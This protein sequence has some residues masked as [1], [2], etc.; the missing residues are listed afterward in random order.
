MKF[1][2]PAVAGPAGSPS[3]LARL[4]ATLVA[5]AA[6]LDSS[7]AQMSSS[8]TTQ[9]VSRRGDGTAA[10][11]HCGGTSLSGDGRYVCFG[12]RDAILPEDD[13][14]KMDVYVL[15]RETGDIVCASTSSVGD[16]GN[17]S[18]SYGKISAD[19]RFV[20]FGNTSDDLIV[21]DTNGFSDVF[22]KDLQTGVLT[23]ISNAIGSA[24][25]ANNHAA[26]PVLS[27]NGRYVAFRSLAND[28][29]VGDTNGEMD[30]FR[31]DRWT[32]TMLRVSNGPAGE[33][34]GDST[35]PSISGD[36]SRIAFVSDADNLT[37]G[38][39]N[40]ERDVFIVDVG[41]LPTLVTRNEFGLSANGSSI[42][43]AISASGRHVA[44]T[45]TAEDLVGPLNGTGQVVV[46]RLED[47]SFELVSVDPTGQPGSD[48]SGLATLS[49]DGRYVAFLS[50]TN[51]LA[52]YESVMPDIFVRDTLEDCTWTGSRPSGTVEIA[53]DESLW[54]AL[55][56]DGSLLAFTSGATN[57]VPGD[58]NAHH[59]VFLREMHPDPRAYCSATP[60]PG[61]CV[62]SIGTL[63]FPSSGSNFGFTVYAEDVPN[64]SLGFVFYGFGGA[65]EA[66]FQG[67]TLC[68]APVLL[69]GPILHSG[70]SPVGSDCTGTFG[71]DMNSY[72]AG[73]LGGSPHV[74]L[75]LI[76]Q[77]VRLQI[78]GRNSGSVFLTD[79]LEYV[80]GP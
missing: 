34:N 42:S 26:R 32:G 15:D 67:G 52:P 44:F 70:G 59:D 80:V 17:G 14:G 66:P 54:P 27:A 35:T 43:A 78:A 53:N 61:G 7:S 65:T 6:N 13:N 11:D 45:T 33:S 31:F 48:G 74:Q 69:R 71:F 8:G 3:A 47:M 19:G 21:P 56:A 58:V 46:C 51:G 22:V 68:V 77:E 25:S 50:Y 4:G 20:A 73:G 39:T 41:G 76:G 57:M 28:L 75:S 16:Y 9:L 29:I 1:L 40:G 60:S 24:D 30:V 12:T 72:A 62:P 79:A 5:C 37:I 55:S 23:R 38:D 10:Q 63:G 49:A 18:A 2:D 36:G 64:Q